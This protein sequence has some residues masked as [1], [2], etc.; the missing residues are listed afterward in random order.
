VFAGHRIEGVAGRGAATGLGNPS[1]A[2][3]PGLSSWLEMAT[4]QSPA[5]AAGH[6]ADL[7]MPPE[8]ERRRLRSRLLLVAGVVVAVV[9]VITLA[10][11]LDSVR[12]RFAH[13]RPGWLALG[14]VLKILS[15]LSYVVVFRAVFCR[16]MT[17]RMSY[18][19]GMSELGANALFPTGGAGGL[20]LGAWALRRGGMPGAQIAQRTV[21]F[22]LLT[23]AANVGAVIVVGLGLATGIFPGKVS[24][25]LC[26]VPAAAAVL[27]IAATLGAGRL[28][29]MFHRRLERRDGDRPSRAA[30]VLIAISDGVR[31][32]VLLLRG[33]DRQLIAGAIG[34][35]AFDVMIVWST[36]NAF[37][38][39]PPLAIIWMAYLIGE[40]G[41]LLPLPGGI[42][43]VDAGL[44]GTFVLY[45]TPLASATAAVLAYRALALW[46]PALLGATAFVALR[47]TLRREADEI[48]LCA[49]GT[50]IEVVGLGRIVVQPPTPAG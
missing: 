47:R 4:A 24:L 14:A 39:S 27:A 6:A 8:L 13:G 44:V 42:G 45:G 2:A 37:G 32:S 28:A 36:F 31:E 41:G 20:A 22:F 21:A 40:L 26:L 29:G 43:G 34:Y 33:A 11:G 3:K 9:A 18:L 49:P 17:W 25:V 1:T 48:A 30:R 35:L 5:A 23:S 16:R 7:G 46:V 50:E 19:I 12:E 38:S 10:P 15:G